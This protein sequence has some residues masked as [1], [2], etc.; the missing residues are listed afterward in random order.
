MDFQDLNNACF[1]YDF[2]LLITE[3]MV[4]ATTGHKRLT[5]MDGSYNCNQIWMAPA[6][7]VNTTFWTLKMDILL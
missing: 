1:K 2:P 4:N 6:D 5:F 7:E 3:I